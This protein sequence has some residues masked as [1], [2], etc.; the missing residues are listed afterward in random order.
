MIDALSNL[1][2]RLLA[3]GVKLDREQ[4]EADICN[5]VDANEDR[6][7]AVFPNGD[8]EGVLRQ[9]IAEVDVCVIIWVD[10]DDFGSLFLKDRDLGVGHALAF[11]AIGVA[12][13]DHAH[14]LREH[15]GTMN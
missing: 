2:E 11:T 6:I 13:E 4:F 3:R 12:N 7:R 14:A 1:L 8:Y 5:L 15:F 9:I 10:G